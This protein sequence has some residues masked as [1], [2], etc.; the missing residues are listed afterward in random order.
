[1]IADALRYFRD[2]MTGLGR[3]EWK[4]PDFGT[5]PKTKLGRS[6]HLVHGQIRGVS[7]NQDYQSIDVDVVLRIPFAPDR[8]PTDLADEAAEFSDTVLADI[9][10]AKNRCVQT[11][12]KNVTFN[13]M[14]LEK[15]AD[16]ND[17]GVVIELS[18]TVLVLMGTR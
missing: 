3:V 17:N 12:I 14:T 11:G 7:N 1:M 13:T 9:L 4:D 6:F 10:S 8:R 5:I 2:R 18:L 16:S 15:L